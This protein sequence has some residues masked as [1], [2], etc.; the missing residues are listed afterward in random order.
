MK[1]NKK[2]ECKRRPLTAG[3]ENWGEEGEMT[4]NAEIQPFP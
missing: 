3:R 2:K 1:T 4:W